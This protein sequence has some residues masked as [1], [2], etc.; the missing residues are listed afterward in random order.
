MEKIQPICSQIKS[1]LAKVVVGQ[2]DVIDGLL[3]ALFV[4]GH[5]LLEGLSLIIYG[6]T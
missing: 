2:E 3:I 1:E 5:V 6:E 4:G